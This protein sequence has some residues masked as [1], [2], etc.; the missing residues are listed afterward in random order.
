MPPITGLS[1]T[2]FSTLKSPGIND[3][4]G[5]EKN[6]FQD[7]FLL[8]FLKKNNVIVAYHY[9]LLYFCLH[10]YHKLSLVGSLGFK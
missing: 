10:H 7:T 8:V 4:E 2:Q 3:C 5:P 6:A 9:A 1:D